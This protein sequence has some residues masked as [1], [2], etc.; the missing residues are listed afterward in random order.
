MK[1]SIF[2]ASLILTGL[3]AQAQERLN[4]QNFDSKTSFQNDIQSPIAENNFNS[5]YAKL[6]GDISNSA[7]ANKSDVTNTLSNKRWGQFRNINDNQLQTFELNYSY[8]N[9]ANVNI[10][11]LNDNL[12]LSKTISF[13]IPTTTND[14]QIIT[15][16]TKTVGPNDGKLKF[17]VY[18]HYFEG[19]MGPNFQKNTIYI[20]NQDGEKL[21]ELD[22]QFCYFINKPDGSTAILT[23]LD[24]SAGM[25]YKLYDDQFN[26]KKEYLVEKFRTSNYAGNPLSFIK[27]NGEDKLVFS[28]YEKQ[29]MNT[30]MVVTPDNHLL[31]KIAD[32]DL[33]FEKEIKLNLTSK[34]PNENMIFALGNFGTLPF[35]EKYSITSHNY[36]A[37]DKLEIT[38]AL[39]YRDMINDKTWSNYYVASEDGTIIKE[40]NKD[41]IALKGL[42]PIENEKDQ[43]GFIVGNDNVISSIDMLNLDT[44]EEA[45]SFPVMF[46]NLL[47]TSNFDRFANNGTYSYMLGTNNGIK[48]NNTNKSYGLINQVSKTGVVEK[49][50][51]LFIGYDPVGF[52]VMLNS[53]T[54]N[55]KI[56]NN[57][58]DMEFSYVHFQKLPVGTKYYNTYSVS[59]GGDDILFTK[60]GQGTLGDVKSASFLR[61]NDNTKYTKMGIVYQVGNAQIITSEFFDLPLTKALAT[62]DTKNEASKVYVNKVTQ[63]LTWKDNA[64]EYQIYSMSGQLIKK[65]YNDNKTSIYGIEKGV[66]IVKLK[67]KKGLVT[68]K[69]ILN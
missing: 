4:F 47:L 16:G 21:H 32:L 6:I 52:T 46:N 14:V 45:V 30:S 62:H 63:M 43:V 50:T 65:G 36:N 27:I 5:N 25:K 15:K 54:L 29:F 26:F 44:M 69:F 51:K 53:D 28:H 64:E 31:V 23:A 61:N 38:Y 55:P 24:T 42:S 12:E 2:L 1:K 19:G 10:K 59:K 37:D 48:D 9:G 33:N 22:A 40:I 68:S 20:I 57:D 66:Y 17:G 49:E 11:L 7:S 35:A 39:S 8:G 67:Y 13:D 34:L 41:V 56:Y 3:F 60:D 18:A 58:E